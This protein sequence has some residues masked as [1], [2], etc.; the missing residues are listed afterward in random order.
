[1]TEEG[2]ANIIQNSVL[3][4]FATRA[5]A[6]QTEAS[7]K[8]IEASRHCLDLIQAE[9]TE[10]L[11]FLRKFNDNA[12]AAERVSAMQEWLKGAS[13]RGAKNASYAMETA[14]A[15]ADI[16]SRLFARP[17]GEKDAA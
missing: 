11:E 1:M 10:A 7:E 6:I 5:I 2:K 12:T 15:L 16:E 13:E 17:S 14:R 4:T 3:P 8:L 9:S